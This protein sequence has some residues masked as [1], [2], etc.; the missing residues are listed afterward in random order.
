MQA[1]EN[2]DD[3]S[4]VFIEGEVFSDNEGDAFSTSL[5][6]VKD[7]ENIPKVI[8]QVRND[9]PVVH[10]FCRNRFHVYCSKTNTTSIYALMN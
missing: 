5:I 7:P 2:N 4:K 8:Q 9:Q 10:I 6:I 3:D 1:I